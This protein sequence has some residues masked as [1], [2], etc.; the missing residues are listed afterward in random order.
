VASFEVDDD[1]LTVVGSGDFPLDVCFDGRRIFSFWLRR[2]TTATGRARRMGWPPALRRF[3]D[4][5]T[6]LSLVD[7][8]TGD[9]LASAEVQLGASPGRIAVVDG[10][11]EPL[12]L[13]KS[14]RLSHL[15]GERTTE[16]AKPVLQAMHTV[17]DALDTAGVEGFLAYG[18][19]LGAVRDQNFIGHDSDADL[20]YV[21]QFSEPVQVIAE[22]FTLQRR[23]QDM[24]FSVHRYSGIAF[25]I[26]LREADGAKR[27][28]DVF[29][30]FMRDGHL[31]LMGEV[32]HPF[33][34]AWVYPRRT[35]TMAGEE[36]PVPAHPE[37]FLE[38][39]Y[40]E[41][42]RV[43]DPAFKFQTPRFAYRRLNGWFRGMRVGLDARFESRRSGR[44]PKP[45]SGGSRFVEW[46]A[47]QEDAPDHGVATFV[48][49]GCGTG[50]D[51]LWL[52]RRGHRGVGLD[53]FPPDLRRGRRRAAG[54]QVQDLATFAWLNLDDYRSVFVSAMELVRTP[55]PRV[56]LARHVAD[57]L[58]RFA[59]TNLL[60]LSRRLAGSSGLL[61]LQVQV[62]PTPY[63]RRLRLGVSDLDRLTALVTDLGGRVRSVDTLTEAEDG[64]PPAQATADVPA[65][66]R[67]V[68][69]W[70]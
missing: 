37:R 8:A 38:V 42:W 68:V 16:H 61:Y 10:N 7:P 18:T 4:G 59:L 45:R 13:D 32:G 41:G 15:F 52:A 22:S 26:I 67:L 21:S 29:G 25:K 40:G 55:E 19:L 48:D 36:F 1:G 57:G 39:M 23:L 63:S 33:E 58:D 12:G 60:R 49:L 66:A 43:P 9:E 28:L 3:L 14:L 51:I 70:E 54:Q 34:R 17:L 20:G 53:C 47:G 2:D 69:S 27:G 62:A 31:F 65:I 64:V 30:G 11:G 24:G 44:A 35:A 56:V 5:R 50:A 6:L 46:V